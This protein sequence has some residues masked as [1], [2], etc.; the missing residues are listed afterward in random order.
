MSYVIRYHVVYIQVTDSICKIDCDSTLLLISSF[1]HP[2]FYI[3]SVSRTASLLLVKNTRWSTKPSD[4]FS[5]EE[6]CVILVFLVVSRTKDPFISFEQNAIGIRSRTCLN[7]RNFSRK[8]KLP[9]ANKLA[10]V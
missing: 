9:V 5:C 1:L 7:W 6:R 10:V 2:S 8:R 4:H 3:K